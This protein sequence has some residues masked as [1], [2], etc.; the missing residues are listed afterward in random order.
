MEGVSTQDD[1]RPLPDIPYDARVGAL[2]RLAT[3]S[4]RARSSAQI[5]ALHAAADECC[6][7][8]PDIA[9]QASALA[10]EATNNFLNQR[11]EAEDAGVASSFVL[12]D[13]KA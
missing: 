12:I 5:E 9:E 11:S 6:A 1:P 2:M 7:R 13:E 10:W 8:F 3:L 4:L